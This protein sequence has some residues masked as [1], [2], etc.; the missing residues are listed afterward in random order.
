MS[1]RQKV[2][3]LLFAV[4]FVGAALFCG[5]YIMRSFSDVTGSSVAQFGLVEMFLLFQ[6]ALTVSAHRTSPSR[7]TEQAICTYLFWF[8]LMFLVIAV[9]LLNPAYRWNEKDTTTAIVAL[10]LTV[11]TLSFNYA[12]GS[13]LKDPFIRALFAI[14]YKS[15]PQV[16]LAWK[17]LAEGASGTPD[18]SVYVGHATI[19]IRLGQIYFMGKEA[20]WDRNRMWLWRSEWANEISWLVATVAWFLVS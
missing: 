9:V 1:S 14:A 17:F 7:L 19:L 11:L 15:V 20:G 8:I 18:L 12:N 5:G 13:S 10:V 6:L 2:T 3:D 4:Q 16:L